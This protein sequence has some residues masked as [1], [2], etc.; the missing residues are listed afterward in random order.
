MGLIYPTESIQNYIEGPAQNSQTSTNNEYY[1]PVYIGFGLQNGMGARQESGVHLENPEFQTRWY[2]KYF[3][4][5]GR[6]TVVCI[7]ERKVHRSEQ[8]RKKLLVTSSEGNDIL[9]KP[10]GDRRAIKCI[11][12]VCVCVCVCVVV[13][14]WCSFH[15]VHSLFPTVHQ[16]YV[17]IDGDKNPFALSVCL[18]DANNFGVP[19][20]RAILWRKTVSVSC[21]SLDLTHLDVF[22]II[23]RF[24]NI[25]NPNP[26]PT[27]T[28]LRLPSVDICLQKLLTF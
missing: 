20:Y 17:G 15:I 11:V 2:F 26:P 1:W 8:E 16:N 5:K 25:V 4:G 10:Y 12:C 21:V 23:D 24:K 6:K 3:L 19:Q 7:F 28:L 14:R 9:K 18:T 27:P 13:V 22:N